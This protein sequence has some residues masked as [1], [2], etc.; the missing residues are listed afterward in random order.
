MHK[1]QAAGN[2]AHAVHGAVAGADV[3]VCHRAGFSSGRSNEFY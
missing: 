1:K 3:G 2:P